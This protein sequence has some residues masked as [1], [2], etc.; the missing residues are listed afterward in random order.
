MKRVGVVALL[1]L[2]ASVM[3][4]VEI[5]IREPGHDEVVRLI[6]AKQ[7]RIAREVAIQC[8]DKNAD[9]NCQ[10]AA[11]E[12]LLEG[13]G[14]KV[15]EK[16]A[17]RYLTASAEQGSPAAQALL[18]NVYHNGVGVKKDKA[19]AVSWWERSAGNCNTWAQDAV[20]HS[21]FD[22]ELVPQDLVRAFH[23]V[24]VA[25][26]FEYPDSDKGAEK[27]RELLKPEQLEAARAMTATFLEKSGC[28]TEKP[29]VVH[30]P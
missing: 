19:V 25:A 5:K 21:Y 6:A 17:V 28:G 23:W 27:L 14:G 12:F 3:A 7:Y 4:Q 13:V 9:P 30:Q 15:D 20:A 2:S 18:G 11:A 24:S 10:L 16:G 26:H 22:G 29:V 8:A 1:C